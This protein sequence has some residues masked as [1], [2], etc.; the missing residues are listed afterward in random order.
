MDDEAVDR[1]GYDRVVV[2]SPWEYARRSDEFQAWCRA[3]GPDRLRNPPDLV[4]FNRD[5]RS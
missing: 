4:A 5:E 1:A 2:R 3:I